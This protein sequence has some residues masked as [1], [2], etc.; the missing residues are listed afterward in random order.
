[1]GSSSEPERP[2]W[3]GRRVRGALSNGAGNAVELRD[4]LVEAVATHTVG[5]PVDDD[6]TLVV[7]RYKS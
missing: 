3:T 2:R 7:M 1:M 6:R 5:K 4:S